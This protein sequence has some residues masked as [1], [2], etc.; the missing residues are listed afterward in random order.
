MAPRLLLHQL[1]KTLTENVYFQP[2][3]TIQISYPC[4]VYRRDFA[5]S[6]YADNLPYNYRQ[7]YMVTIIDRSP[8]SEIIPK[9][10]ELPTSIFNRNYVTDNLNHDVFNVYF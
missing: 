4:I 5:N 6:D 7:R 10:A 1:L 9:V 3:P 8:D 2:P